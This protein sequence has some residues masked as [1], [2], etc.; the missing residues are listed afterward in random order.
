VAVVISSVV[1]LVAPA[2][3]VLAV[4]RIGLR[5]RP[6]GP[7]SLPDP[8]ALGLPMAGPAS[9]RAA[10]AALSRGGGAARPKFRT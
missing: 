8:S 2:L 3:V 9:Q 5:L 7:S 1:E 10:H 4:V 6:Q